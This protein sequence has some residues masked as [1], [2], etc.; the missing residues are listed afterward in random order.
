MVLK[1][2]HRG[3]SG[4]A[5]ENS[6]EAFRMALQLNSDVIEFDVHSTKD[7]KLIVMHDPS[8]DRVTNGKGMINNLTLNEIKKYRLSNGKPIPTFYE[9]LD[10]LM[11]RCVCKIDIKDPIQLCLVYVTN[12]L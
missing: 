9:V 11:H 2:A 1:I 4:Y 5:I 10:L 6:I 12:E 7:G 8:I 3:A